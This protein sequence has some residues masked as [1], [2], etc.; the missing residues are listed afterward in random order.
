M[1]KSILRSMVKSFYDAQKLRIEVGNRICQNVR[2][3]LGQKPGT[4]T[5]DMDE[6]AQNLL[7]SLVVEYKRIADA[8]TTSSNREKIKA[9]QAGD[10]IITDLFEYNLVGYYVSLLAS[11]MQLE[12]AIRDAVETF[13]IW[14]KFLAGVRGCG[15]LMA[16]V[17]ISELDPH[18]AAHVSSFWRYA[19]LDVVVDELG[20]C[21]G[22]SRKQH[23]LVERTYI[24]K[25]GEEATRKGIAF[26][27]LLKTKLVGVLGSVFI[28]LGGEY[29][30]VYDSYKFRLEH[31]PDTAGLTKG[32]KH[33]RAVRY[34]IKIFLRDLW[35][36]WREVEGL[37]VT[38]DYAE[39]KLGI[40]HSA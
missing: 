21:E 30:Q 40:K 18:K 32:H 22:R 35:L 2:V 6:K 1:D 23:H 3:R 26:N 11:E 17:I 4:K 19:G 16:A 38:P 33:N 8:L 13:P 37:P 27:P 39:G 25:N 12:E 29:R 7:A 5:E 10:G 34:M 14:E 24:N 31:R 15:P 20:R 9:I 28:K 36:A